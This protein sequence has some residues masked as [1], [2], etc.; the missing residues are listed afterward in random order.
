V[1]VVS[2]LGEVAVRITANINEFRANL[3]EAETRLNNFGNGIRSTSDKFL[4][5]GKAAGVA[6][7]AI[8]AGLGYAVKTAM[9]FDAQMSKIKALSGATDEEFKKLR[10]TAI[11]LGSKS[12]F[13]SS[14]AAKGMESLAAAGFNTQQVVSAMP[15]LLDAAAAS[16][17]DFANVSDIMVAAMSGFGLQAGDMGHIA[18]V[19]ASAANASSISISDI[20]Y[21][22][23]YVAPVAKS[24]G[25]SIEE[26]SAALAV[27]GN[28]GIKA[29]QAGT[30][31]RMSLT[32]LA[33]PPKEAAEMLQKLGIQVTDSKGK[34]L[35]LSNIIGQL[36]GSFKNLDQS[37]K[38][39]AASTIF[40]AETM[41]A[42]LTLIEAGPE[43]LDEL[44][45]AFRN[46]D[47]AAKE[48]S[49]TMTD[50]LAGS[51]EQL[52]GAAESALISIGS[53]LS[54]TLRAVADAIQG[55]INRFNALPEPVK[56]TIAVIAAVTTAM[57]LLAAGIGLII[58][59]IPS[60][61]AGLS[62]LVGVFG[63]LAGAVTFLLSP[64]GLVVA[65]IAAL[66]AIGVA[67]Y[68][69]WDEVKVFLTST[70]K[71]IAS[72]AQSVW[73]G[74][75]G[76]FTSIGQGI[77]NTMKSMWD[78]LKAVFQTYA[79]KLKEIVTSLLNTIKQIWTDVVNQIKNTTVQV[80]ES[81]KQFFINGL[82]AIKSAW[83][84]AWAAIQN[85]FS[86]AWNSIINIFHSAPGQVSS[87]MS[88]IGSSV[89]NAFSSMASSAISAGK[90]LIQGFING[91]GSMAGA[92]AG[93]VRS[94]VSSAVDSAK[95]ALGIHSPSKVFREIGKY[96]VKGFTLGIDR[97]AFQA[98]RAASGMAD[99]VIA[100]VDGMGFN[101]GSLSVAGGTA[102]AAAAVGPSISVGQ[103]VVREEADIYRIAEELYRL[104]KRNQRARG[105]F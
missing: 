7:T 35:P 96:T 2:A 4:V 33:A 87:A 1:R 97:N 40:G 65:A 5:I 95:R 79:A 64:I 17:E 98:V 51:L 99:G 19:L 101:S 49:N 105:G 42:M 30:S 84:N 81:I 60:I 20:G 55:V 37:Q 80:W 62:A 10:D 72:A 102:G 85:T 56:N 18:D 54:P 75:A 74:I 24:F 50:N 88:N 59:F 13:S 36:S 14:E 21:S 28:S 71:S 47:G 89:R 29:D 43:K 63:A 6:G 12:V 94:V 69:K 67:L 73:K 52:K 23:K 83:S 91:V 48:M 61:I 34:I 38:L 39:E 8:A 103:L 58:G 27:L 82:N 9:D 26:V 86:N 76:F 68:V 15:G 57:T 77:A 100:A 3:Q 45:G 93:K 53:A 66:I 70:W 104:Q 11:D 41:S 92:L 25:T 22:L 46:S 44:T 32:R 90:N 16:G 31:L 78:G